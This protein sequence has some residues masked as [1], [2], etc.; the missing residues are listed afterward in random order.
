MLAIGG[1]DS[2]ENPTTY[3]HMYNPTTNSWQLINDMATPRSDCF[4][5][6]L[7]NNQLMVVGGYTNK[8]DHT[9]TDSIELATVSLI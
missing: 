4:A 9:E 6:V 1:K 2:D 8:H 5:A 7:K 3:V